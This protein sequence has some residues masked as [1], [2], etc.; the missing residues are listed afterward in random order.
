MWSEITGLQYLLQ[1]LQQKTIQRLS[2]SQ[3]VL[4]LDFTAQES[5]T[6][7]TVS[8]SSA[9]N[10]NGALSQSE[11]SLDDW[12]DTYTSSLLPSPVMRQKLV[13]TL[14]SKDITLQML[15]HNSCNT[16]DLGLSV[17]HKI[18]LEQGIKNWCHS[19]AIRSTK[20]EVWL[21]H[22]FGVRNQC[23]CSFMKRT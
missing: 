18:A 4:I 1:F 8:A 11:A 10:T 19:M 14:D 6:E 15:L 13:Q 20:D 16:A 7:I 12:I 23:M 5:T 21:L 9:S 3:S 17:G 2:C 22:G